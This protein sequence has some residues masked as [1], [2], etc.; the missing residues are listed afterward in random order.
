MV[1]IM[2]SII[3]PVYNK[4]NYLEKCLDSII[5][6][7]YDNIEVVLIDDGS[8]DDSA[9]I[10][11]RYAKR[12]KRFIFIRQGNKGVSVTRNLGIERARGKWI[13]FLDSDDFLDLDA[14]E[15]LVNTAES[16]KS[17][18]VYFGC[19]EYDSSGLLGVR[20]LTVYK[21]YSNLRCFLNG[22]HLQPL[23]ACVNFIRKDVIDSHQVFFN[24][25]LEHNEDGLF[26]YSLYCHAK[27]ITTLNKA[28]YNI[29]LSS[30]SISR[31][32][33]SMKVL[34]DNLFFVTELSKYVRQRDLVLE[35]QDEINNL[36]KS[37]FVLAL[38][39]DSFEDHKV[40][41]QEYYRIFYKENNDILNTWFTK[42]GSL[43]ISIIVRL[44][45][46]VH[47]LKNI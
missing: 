1:N 27:R 13:C 43:D 23:S 7:T 29:Y 21:E 28:L 3:V 9:I 4:Q 2:V 32:A 37:F 26:M 12:D 47:Y 16:S 34:R 38:N 44:L 45:K 30:D 46:F 33:I 10:C 35:Y 31:K 18:I 25:N 11:S 6:Q 5:N 22:T 41:L 42:I 36:S 14:I 15:I 39:F 17:D 40:E 20:E 8:T 24:E 19:R